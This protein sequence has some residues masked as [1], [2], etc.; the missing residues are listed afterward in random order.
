MSS[1]VEG[2]GPV[3]EEM[4]SAKPKSRSNEDKREE[5]HS[6]SS[7]CAVYKDKRGGAMGAR[8]ASGGGGTN[9]GEQ[10]S[11]PGCDKVSCSDESPEI[12]EP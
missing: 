1:D 3:G 12:I 9:P 11:L 4:N 2:I 10:R 8:V 6:P 5:D 7:L